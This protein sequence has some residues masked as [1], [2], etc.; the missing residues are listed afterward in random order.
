MGDLLAPKASDRGGLTADPAA[1][2][3]LDAVLLDARRHFVES[4]P[5]HCDMLAELASQPSPPA[6]A[7][8]SAIAQLH[9]IAGLGGTIGF[10][11]VSAQAAELEDVL[12][13]AA[14]IP[15]SFAASVDALRKAFDQDEAE[16]PREAAAPQPIGASLTVLLVEDN[17]VQRTIVSGQLRMVGHHPIAV[18]SGEEALTAA[19][20]TRPDVILLDVELP[21]MNGHEVCRMLK[22][23]PALASVPVAFLTA[24]TTL[25]DRLTGLSHG[26]DDFLT[27]P[28]DPRELALRLQLLTKRRTPAPERQSADLLTYDAFRVA[29][30]DELSRSRAAL[31][32]VRT[33]ADK[34]LD[35]AAF[36][37]DEIR[38]R[39]L[40]GEY[41][42][43][44]VIVLLPDMSAT[45]ARQRIGSLVEKCLSNGV[46]GVCAGVAA[47]ERGGGRTFAELLE[48]ADEALAC[49]RYQKLPAALRPEGRHADGAA[50][51]PERAAPLVLIADDDPDVVRILDAHLAA[52]GFRRTLAFD[53]SRALEEVR[54]Q[55]PDIVILDLMMPRLTGFDVLAGLRDLEGER[56]HIIVLSAR[57]RED[58]VIRAFSFGADDFMTKPF[59][60]QELLARVG[61]LVK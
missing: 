46:T 41:D 15:D 56:P 29:A 49:A 31:A 36:I 58:D 40:C 45:A 13:A 33:P 23:D 59:N 2:Q 38:R 39:D 8:E 53:G 27:K 26:A 30:A 20:K 47:S 55:H 35:V 60:P 34:T 52:G 24:H 5:A 1:A 3:D 61:R 10:P 44:H 48:E 50:P 25:D 57:G 16:R 11:R 32:L 19:R 12:R 22:A 17:V 14:P 7:L 28:L 9:R 6:E 4:F 37:R 43:T 54:A 18:A 51:Q 42:R 21:G